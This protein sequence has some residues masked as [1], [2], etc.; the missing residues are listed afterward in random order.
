M[1]N[2]TNP[3]IIESAQAL[4]AINRSEIDMQISTAKQ[5]PRDVDK[6]LANIEKLATMDEE[7][8][9]GC[10]YHLER[11]D[12]DGKNNDIDGLS[13]RM[14][15]I[16]ATQW[17]NLRA[18]ARIIANDGRFITSQGVCHD[19]ETNVAISVEVKRRITNK[20]GRTYSDDMQMVAGNAACAIAF[21]NAVLKVVPKAVTA[22]VVKKVQQKAISNVNQNLNSQRAKI[23]DFFKK[24]NISIEKVLIWLKRDHV[25]SITAEDVVKLRGLVT[26]VQE[27]S[28]TYEETFKTESDQ[29]VLADEAARRAAEAKAK[30]AAAVK[31]QKGTINNNPAQGAADNK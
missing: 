3:I 14:A 5:F 20:F 13:V 22:T 25:E 4:E 27:G 2:E 21:R 1:S 18:Q 24:N 16:I 8:A 30:A 10:F 12:A 28:T 11:R 19:L 23:I 17:G 29:K 9:E 26:A 7:T 15:E 6:A 31:A